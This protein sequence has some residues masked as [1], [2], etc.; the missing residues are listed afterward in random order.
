MAALK[1][2]DSHQMIAYLEKYIENANFDEIV[3]FLNAN[4]IRYALTVCPTV[5][6]PYIEQFWS[7]VKAKPI[8]EETEIRAKVNGKKIVIT[9]SSV[10]RNLQLNDADEFNDVFNTP[11]HTKKIFVNMRRQGKDF[12]GTLTPLFATMLIQPQADMGEGLGQSINPQHSSTTTS[13]STIEPILVPSSSQPKKTQKHRKTIRKA[14]KLPQTSRPSEPVADEAVN[15]KWED[16]VVSATSLD[17]EHDSGTINRNQS[18]AIPNDLFPQGIGSSGRP[19]RQETK[20]T[21]L[22]KQGLRVCLNSLMIHHSEELTHIKALE[23]TNLKKRF[24]KLERKNKS[25]TLQLKQMVYKARVESF[26]ESLGYQEDASKQGRKILKINQHKE[27]NTT[28]VN[29]VEKE[30]SVVEPVTTASVNVNVASPTTT[31]VAD[32]IDQED[33]ILA[34]TLMAIKSTRLKEKSITPVKVKGKD[35]ISYDAEVAQRIQA[36]LD[37]EVRLEREKEEEASN[38]VLIEE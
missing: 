38:A 32:I 9:E 35:K 29:V 8:N 3:D 36:E 20:G 22:L 12:L 17:A 31:T 34:Q 23:I 27:V 28:D 37:E 6:V 16:S 5:Y 26:E 24:K 33:I 11:S 21:D 30:I 7:S 2:A 25:R 19:R 13:P 4:P 10:W 15:K 18:T 1:F 14:T